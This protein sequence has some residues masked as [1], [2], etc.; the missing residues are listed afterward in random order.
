VL[1]QLLLLAATAF[2][3]QPQQFELATIK[4]T[5]P[6]WRGGRYTRMV[7]PK[8]FVATNFTLRVLIAAAY[9]LNPRAVLGGPS[10][11]D[12]D[13]YD[14]VALVP[15]EQPETPGV[16]RQMAML[17]L[18]LTERFGLEFRR[19]EKEM[20]LYYLS[21]AKDGPKLKESKSPPD[22]DP[23]IVN[24]I[25]A[26]HVELPARNAS[27]G[28][29]AAILQRSIFNRPV[30]DKT[31][32]MGRYDFDLAWTADSSQFDGVLPEQSEPAKPGFYA[33]IQQQIGLKLEASKGLVLTLVI[34]KIQRPSEN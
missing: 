31:G 28:E 25:F 7:S 19:E 4:P 18:L 15:G 3:T 12:T 10:W 13:R 5:P 21:I 9:K 1:S 33:A 29:F 30:V 23:R 8:R 32:L 2:Q 24:V 34:D 20:P 14:I 6:D 22:Q 11:I 16:F 26:D 17:Q 27:M